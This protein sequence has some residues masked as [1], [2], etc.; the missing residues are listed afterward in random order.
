MGDLSDQNDID[1]FVRS[2][3]GETYL[4]EIVAMLKGRTIVD[5]TFSNEVSFIDATLELDDGSTYVIMPPSLDVDALRE[6]FGDILKREYYVDY[7]ERLPEQV[8]NHERRDG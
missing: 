2:S 1:R 3:E 5:V 7:P 6:E 8:G 4:N